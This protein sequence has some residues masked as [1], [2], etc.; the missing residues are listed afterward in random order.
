MYVCFILNAYFAFV[1][2]H[3]LTSIH[4][5]IGSLC[6]DLAAALSAVHM[7]FSRSAPTHSQPLTRSLLSPTQLRALTHCG[8]G[9]V[10]ITC[11]D[12]SA[13]RIAAACLARTCAGVSA[14]HSEEEKEVWTEVVR[15]LV[16]V[17]RLP[18]D[19]L[20]FPVK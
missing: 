9:S 8:L 3:A 13:M 4:T 6:S 2:Y 18:L 5:Q 20:D 15:A 16:R 17:L 19:Q 12:F 7:I 14:K 10:A 11:K 1:G